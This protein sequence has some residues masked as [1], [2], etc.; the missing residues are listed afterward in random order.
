MTAMII[1][2]RHLTVPL[3]VGLWQLAAAAPEIRNEALLVDSSPGYKIGFQAQQQDRSRITEMVPTG[4]TVESWTEMVTV[5]TFPGLTATPEQF[6]SHLVED[7][8][9]ACPKSDYQ[10]IAQGTESGYAF[11]LWLLSCP[12]NKVSGKPEITWFKAIR[13]NDSLYVVQKAFRF[14]PSKEQIVTWMAFLKDAKVCDT[15]LP[16]RPCP[17]VTPVEH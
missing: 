14:A 9:G 4:E 13:G 3:A 10:R 12:L 5:Q 1:R 16:D 15:R 7:W 6:E 17:D 11:V 2:S 8:R